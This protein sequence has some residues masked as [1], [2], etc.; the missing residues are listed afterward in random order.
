MN[1]NES[2]YEDSYLK[3]QTQNSIFPFKHFL[4]K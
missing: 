3:S 2:C 1:D 4:V